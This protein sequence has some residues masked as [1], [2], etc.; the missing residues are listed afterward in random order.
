MGDRDTRNMADAM[1]PLLA[2]LWELRPHYVQAGWSQVDGGINY[3]AVALVFS[4][5]VFVGETYLDWRQHRLLSSKEI[6]PELTT[7]MK[8]MDEAHEATEALKAQAAAQKSTDDPD[9]EGDAPSATSGAKPEEDGEPE[10]AQGDIGPP[11][12]EKLETKFGESQRYGHDKS[13]FGFVQSF[14]GQT[15]STALMLLGFGPWMYDLSAK[16]VSEHILGT[17]VALWLG[18]APQVLDNQKSIALVFFGCAM[19]VGTVTSLP[20][21]LYFSFVI[22]ERHGFNKQTLKL[23]FMDQL[24]TMLLTVIIGAPIVTIILSIID[25]G[26]PNFYI[27]VWLFVCVLSLFMMVIYP[28]LIAP[29]FNK[30]DPLPPGPLKDRIETLAASLKFPLTKLFVVDGSTRSAHSN[31]YMYGFHKNKRIVLFDTLIKQLHE[32]E[33]VG[34]LSHELG[35]WKMGHTLQGFAIA[36]LHTLVMFASFGHFINNESL[37]RSFGYSTQSTAI[38]LML[39]SEVIWGPVDK[40]LSLLMN[41]W[42]RHNEFEADAFGCKLGYG[43]HLMS[44]LVKIHLANMGNMKPDAWYSTYHYSHPPLVER[45]VAMTTTQKSKT[46]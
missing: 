18:L 6:P 25:W 20:F 15:E 33:I 32:E 8:D 2:S 45:L 37:F 22:E 30:F 14:W 26:G 13:C 10:S 46:A 28:T 11:F 12:L 9:E 5:V 1:T 39:F 27:Y 34:V 44:G 19:L 24:K 35:H 23:F 7:A 3:F 38:G 31:A 29:M 16:I 42:S 17:R 36:Q 41:I 43:P 21:S 4:F 40:V